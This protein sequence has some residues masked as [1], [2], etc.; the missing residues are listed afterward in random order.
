MNAVGV[1]WAS[2]QRET[3]LHMAVQGTV[4]ISALVPVPL[5]IHELKWKKTKL[6]LAFQKHYTL[7]CE[8]KGWEKTD[9]RILFMWESMATQS[10]TRAL[11]IARFRTC[12]VLLCC[13]ASNQPADRPHFVLQWLFPWHGIVYRRSWIMVTPCLLYPMSKSILEKNR[14]VFQS[15][16]SP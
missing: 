2:W 15:H 12:L 3:K 6:W 8:E 5:D 9:P 10:R 16:F 4:R 13:A 14:E 1:E 11:F 7:L